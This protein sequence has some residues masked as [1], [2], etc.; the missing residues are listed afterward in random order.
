MKP[1]I[2]TDLTDEQYRAIDAVNQSQL[3][4]FQKSAKAVY[5]SKE[6]PKH[7]S[8]FK[9]G[10]AADL[11]LFNPERFSEEFVEYSGSAKA[12][13]EWT[14]ERRGKGWAEFKEFAEREGKQILTEAELDE[15]Q[16]IAKACHQHEIAAGLLSDGRAHTVV[17]WR[18]EHTGLLCK[19]Q[20][21]Y[22]QHLESEDHMIVDVKTTRSIT[23]RAWAADSFKYG[24]HVQ[25]AFYLDGLF[26]QLYG[27]FNSTDLPHIGFTDIAVEK[28]S[29][30]PEVVC[31]EVPPQ[32]IYYGRQ[33]YR[34][35]LEEYAACKES[36]V[37]PGIAD[38]MTMQTK[39]PEWIREKVE[40]DYNAGYGAP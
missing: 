8:A 32:L 10:Q 33:Q 28:G 15:A 39:P 2:Y 9:L 3:K 4:L 1:G 38:R 20:L 6:F 40:L 31:Y 37:W 21:D 25:A 27:G 19:A 18:D 11:L 14:T 5:E 35:W 22:L 30:R 7:S 29:P 16:N 13:G 36:G 26:D 24:Y 17:I 34:G 23:P 12:D